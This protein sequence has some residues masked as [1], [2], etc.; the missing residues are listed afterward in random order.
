M[1]AVILFL[2]IV[3][4][5]YVL[6]YMSHVKRKP[7]FCIYV[8]TEAQISC[9]VIA[10][11][12]SAFVFTT[13]IVQS[14]FLNPEFQASSSLLWLYSPVCIGPGRKTQRKVFLHHGSNDSWFFIF[15]HCLTSICS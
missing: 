6:D 10:Q 11:L 13:Q 1:I 3:L 14:L 12:I 4:L 7:F 9:A 2:L 5:L 15:A 8:K